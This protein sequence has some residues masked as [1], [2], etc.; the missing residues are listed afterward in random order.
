MRTK[1]DVDTVRS[2]QSFAKYG[3]INWAKFTWN[4]FQDVVVEVQFTVGN[5]FGT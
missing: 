1:E 4:H 3:V 2:E 5:P